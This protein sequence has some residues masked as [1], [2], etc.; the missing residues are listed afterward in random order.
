[1]AAPSSSSPDLDLDLDPL[2]KDLTQKKLSFKKNVVS[3]ATEL[4]D[5]RSRLAAQHHLFATERQVAE[6]KART[7]EQEISNLQNC[8]LHKDQ[9]LRL[10]SSTTQQ[11]LVELDDLRSQLSVT[12]ATA[13]S[14]AESAESAQ[15]QCSS[16]LEELNEKQISLKQHEDRVNR[17]GEQVE[18]LQKLL[19]TRELSHQQLRDEVLQMEKEITSAVSK[20]GSDRDSELR[21]VLE[22]VSPKNIENLNRLLSAKDEE[23]ARLRDEIRILSAH[24]INKTKELESQLE[25]QRRTDQELKKKILKLEFCLQESRSQ[26]RKLQRMGERRDKALKEL[27][28]LVAMK[29]PNNTGC[30][31]KNNF[32]ESSGF[33]FMVSMSMLAIVIV[34]KR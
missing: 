29:L 3:L 32:W 27:R 2:L 19:E 34:A 11:F 8:L 14:S 33:K 20:A 12:R 13:E 22:E 17:L 25:K 5:V 6:S 1:M 4:K 31:E 15:A 9:Q 23:I 18:H 21:R 26:I 10:S 24:W 28:D 7:M 30:D 16:L